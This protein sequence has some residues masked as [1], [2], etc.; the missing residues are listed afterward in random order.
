MG[1]QERDEFKRELKVNSKQEKLK[2]G[3][4]EFY[5]E[6][7][8]SLN[9]LDRNKAIKYFEEDNHPKA[10]GNTR[11]RKGKI[12]SNLRRNRSEIRRRREEDKENRRIKSQVKPQKSNIGSRVVA[13]TSAGAIVLGG[14][15]LTNSTVKASDIN[16]TN[17]EYRLQ[18]GEDIGKLGINEDLVNRLQD[19][20]KT[21]S[22]EDL[23]K[24]EGIK[25]IYDT[26]TFNND[27]TDIKMANLLGVDPKS[28]VFS[29]ENNRGE[30]I[31]TA[32]V[33][34]NWEVIHYSNENIVDNTFG[35][36]NK[37]FPLPE[38]AKEI[39]DSIDDITKV[40]GRIQEGKYNTS[41]INDCKKY[42]EIADK[43]AA[44]KMIV[45]ENG[46]I[47]E[48]KE[49][50]EIEKPKVENHNNQSTYDEER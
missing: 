8:E 40:M 14:I 41:M 15:A 7:F 39:I 28:V 33:I 30:K 16:H 49:Q 10:R 3:Y 11:V 25:L 20:Q 27:L 38:S 17:I 6:K 9:K 48:E 32:S 44:T 45:D 50:N 35:Y 37:R 18:Q 19:L 21:A 42:L 31:T 23:T 47:T 43:F 13:A 2:E 4:N 46:K 5:G 36:G 34:K 29:V 26:Y 12:E 1:K 22:R 24:E